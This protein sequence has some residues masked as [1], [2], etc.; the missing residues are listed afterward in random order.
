MSVA[1]E[2][3]KLGE[4]V[5]AF[6]PVALVVTVGASGRP[7]IVS[8][9]VGLAGEELVAEVGRTTSGN[10][11]Q[12]STASLVWPA[13]AG[14]DYCLIVDGSGSVRGEGD[15]QRVVVTPTRAVLHRVADAAGEGPSC[16]TVLD[17]RS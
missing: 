6:G 7:H 2:I 1:V 14:G 17:Q 10:V 4:Q 11:E 5:A 9:R 16:V 8:A 13:A 15:D 12:T 3:A